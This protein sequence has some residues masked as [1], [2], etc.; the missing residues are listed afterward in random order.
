ML[1]AHALGY[2]ALALAD[3]C[4]VSGMVRAHLEAKKCGLKL[5][6]GA[7]F[8]VPLAGTLATA[9]ATA[10]SSAGHTHTPSG[11]SFTLI[12]LAHDLAAWG[13]LCEFITTARRSAPKGQY[14][15]RWPD[16]G[17]ARL[18]GCEILLDLPDAMPLEA[19]NALCIWARG[20]FGINLWLTASQLLR[21]EDA[22]QLHKLTQIS[23]L[24]GVP[25]VATGR[26][27]M[28]L[29]SRKPLQDVLTAVHLGRPVSQCGLALQP[30]A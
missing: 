2:A 30:N 18:K 24:A 26:V 12:A 16:P 8:T 10:A 29:R 15:V 13:D 1:R 23:R 25:L 22:L 6:P 11:A 5:L 19:A 28:H 20:L 27:L 3:A 17:C 21:A 14:S 7:S 4:S 9:G